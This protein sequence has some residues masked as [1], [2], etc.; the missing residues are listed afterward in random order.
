MFSEGGGAMVLTELR[1]RVCEANL[2]L[3]RHGIVLYTWG[4]VS[5]IDRERGAMVI[6]PSGVPYASLTPAK[7]VVVGLNDQVVE[8]DLNPST[9][10]RTHTVLYRAF[11]GIG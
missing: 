8:G 4:N 7:M 1:E 3:H 10:T 2:E 9:D 11:P 6:K 5:G